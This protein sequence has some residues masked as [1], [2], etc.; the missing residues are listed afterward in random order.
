MDEFLKSYADKYE[1]WRNGGDFPVSSR[2]I[3]VNESVTGY[4]LILPADQ[5]LQ[6]LKEARSF[7]LADCAC[8]THYRRCDKPVEVCL[9]VDDAADRS[10]ERNMACRISLAE[11]TGVLEKADKHGLI[12]MTYYLPGRK[13]NA[14]CSC[15]ACCCHD[16]Q[17]LI[18]YGRTDLVAQSDYLAV[19]DPDQCTGCGKCTGRCAFGAREIRDG[20]LRY[21]HGACLGCGLCVSVCP[22]KATRMLVRDAGIVQRRDGADPEY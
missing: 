20:T 4:Q 15:C 7:A 19:T 16:L 6:I 13:I 10:V 12:H 5:L 1:R 3:P 21:D 8:R 18:Q 11:A 17:L 14:V 9:L 2:I 22:V